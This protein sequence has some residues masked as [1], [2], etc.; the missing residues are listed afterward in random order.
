MK[1]YYNVGAS[2]PFLHPDRESFP[3]REEF[4]EI[5]L[6]WLVE[7]DREIL[8]GILAG[9]ASPSGPIAAESVLPE[10]AAFD[11]TLRASLA[12]QR[13]QL[14]G[15]NSG[16]EHTSVEFDPD[17]ERAVAEYGNQPHPLA[18]EE[19]LDTARWNKLEQLQVG[20][21]FDIRYLAVYA[22]KLLLLERRA[23]WTKELGT[24]HFSAAYQQV[25]AEIQHHVP[26]TESGANV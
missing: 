11:R 3:A 12:V 1:Q 25:W 20:H 14:L 15:R 16:D 24:E 19:S 26:K 7:E 4:L 6:P 17:V 23:T 13:S 22:L 2:L 5:C 9:S 10:Y 18:A 8:Q 21:Y